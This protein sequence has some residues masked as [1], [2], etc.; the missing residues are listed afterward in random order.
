MSRQRV[1]VTDPPKPESDTE[2]RQNLVDA[3][4]SGSMRVL[5]LCV[6]RDGASLP[7]VE[8]ARKQVELTTAELSA[9]WQ[10]YRRRAASAISHTHGADLLD[11][12][13][14]PALFAT[15]TSETVDD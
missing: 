12:W 9:S 1:F 7:E 14:T 6:D 13:F 2:L 3:L 4:A 11:A 8:Q 15:D 10:A 5:H